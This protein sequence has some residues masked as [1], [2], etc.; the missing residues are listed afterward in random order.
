MTSSRVSEIANLFRNTVTSS[1]RQIVSQFL[2]DTEREIRECDTEMNK[3]RTTMHALENRRKGLKSA[4]ERC[5]SLLS[6]VRRLPA[7]VLVDIF[8]FAC[9]FNRIRPSSPPSTLCLSMVCGQWR[10]VVLSTSR[11]W[12]SIDIPFIEWRDRLPTLERLVQLFMERSA[13]YPLHLRLDFDQVGLAANV[14]M[15]ISSILAVLAGN[16]ERWKDVLLSNSSDNS[17][18]LDLFSRG[19]W[20]FPQLKRVD[21]NGVSTPGPYPLL[22]KLFKDSPS[23]HALSLTGFGILDNHN[24]R[25]DLPWNQIKLLRIGLA[26]APQATSFLARFPNLEKLFLHVRGG[27]SHVHHTS[28]TIKYLSVTESNSLGRAVSI[29]LSYL[30]LP[31]LISLSIIGG[32]RASTIG[33]E[34]VIT[35]FL[36]RSGCSLASLN[37][38]EI[39]LRDLQVIALLEII[40]TLKSLEIVERRD[41]SPG[42][43]LITGTFLRRFIVAHEPEPLRQGSSFLP[44]LTTVVLDMMQKNEVVEEDFFDMVSSRWIPDA[45]RAREI[46]VECLRSVRIT[47]S[48]TNAG[49][50][51]DSSA[52]EGGLSLESLECFRDAGLRLYVPHKSIAGSV[53]INE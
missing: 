33:R 28:Q 41:V 2:R 51:S 34:E 4:V 5:R 39:A 3:L 7:E 12:S 50:N 22:L 10:T 49:E 32:R 46:G 31:K 42:D 37:L 38:T 11:L 52:S 53:L 29:T 40:P 8:S 15:R 17:I 16:C 25:F 27:G 35:D 48:C 23:L 9:P 13:I 43:Y 6:P 20:A 21:I 18:Y 1:D 47:L 19:A 30:S 26:S 24:D 14:G 44:R 36:A 45:G